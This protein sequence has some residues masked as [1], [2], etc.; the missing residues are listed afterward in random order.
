MIDNLIARLAYETARHFIRAGAA[1]DEGDQPALRVKNLLDAEAEE[2]LRI[3][4][5]SA[6]ADGLGDVRVVVAQDSNLECDDCFR[7]D[8]EKS[9]TWYRNNN[10]TGLLYL[11]T[12]VES[13]EQG[14]ES[15]FTVQDRNYLDGSLQTVGF[16]PERRIV[17]LA[18][19]AVNGSDAP[20]P[21][22]LAERVSEVRLRLDEN[23]VGSGVRAFAA[24]ALGVSAEIRTLT[25][26]AVDH[27]TLDRGVGLA[28]PLLNLLPDEDWASDRDVSRRLLLN[29]RLADHMNPSGVDQDPEV[30][31]ALIRAAVFNDPAGTPLPED[32]NRAWRA[33]CERYVDQ[34]LEEHRRS[35]PFWVYR[36]VF[37]KAAVMG[38]PL[39]D[40][41]REEL[42]AT[43]PDRV[44][45]FD[46]LNVRDGLNLRDAESARRLVE[47]APSPDAPEAG[48]LV[49]RLL[50]A[51][52]KLLRRLAYPRAR[53][54]RDPF[55]RIIEMV[56]NAGAPEELEGAELEVMCGRLV[57]ADGPSVDLFAF[58]YGSTL[59]E[60][61]AM[62][63]TG[64]TGLVLRIEE[65]L[66]TPGRPPPLRTVLGE[67]ELSD[68]HPGVSGPDAP[69][70]WPGVPIELRLWK[71]DGP[72][73]VLI[74]EATNLRWRP[75]DIEWL[76][77]GWLMIAAEDA[78]ANEPFLSSSTS[79]FAQIVAHAIERTTPLA[80]LIVARP[81]Q[82][83]VSCDPTL[84]ALRTAR[85]SFIAE[86]ASGGLASSGIEAYAETW[87][88]L[89]HEVRQSFVPNGVLDERL[90]A[91]AA[92]DVVHCEPQSRALMLMSH[93]LRLRWLARHL[94]E[95][96]RVCSE[97]L[98][99]S[100]RLNSV[101]EGHYLENLELLSAHGQPPLLANSARTLL[102]PVS[103]HGLAEVYA[104]IKQEGQ[105]T[106]AWRA[107]VDEVALR[108]VARQLTEYLRAHPHKSDGV[109]LLLVL[110]AGGS[111]PG[112]LVR[113]VRRGEF[114]DVP[115]RCHVLA[116]RSS[117]ERIVAG[118]QDLETGNR[119][120][121]SARLNPPLQLEL[122]DWQGEVH[123]AGQ[124]EGKQFDL[125]IVPNFF[126]DKVDVNEY[127]DAPRTAAGRFDPLYDRSTYVDLE[128]AAGAVSIVLRPEVSDPVLEDWS[129]I[130]VRLLRSEAIAPLSPDWTDYVKLRIR[131]EE[132]AQL[133][134]ALHECSH[135]VI[136]L[137]RYVGRNQI[138]NLPQ[139]PD[140]LTVREGVGQSGLSTLVVSSNTGRDFV[141]QRLRRKLE[142][143]S[144]TV[145]GLDVE[146]LA[147]GVYDEIREVAPGLILRSMGISRVTEEVL[148]L[149]VAKRIAEWEV[150]IPADATS[151]WISLDEHSEWFGG[152]SGI[153]ADLCRI[154]L[155]R[156][157]GRLQVGVLVVE[158]KLRQAYD[159]HGEAQ[160]SRS[161]R[162]IGEA[163]DPDSEDRADAP[164]WRRAVLN[165]L[166]AVSD[167][168]SL[169][170]VR[171]GVAIPA[172]LHDEDRAA[173][174]AGDYQLAVLRAVYSICLYDR[175]GRLERSDAGEVAVFR[176]GAEQVLDLIE[177]RMESARPSSAGSALKSPPDQ[178]E[179]G[180]PPALTPA[181]FPPL[182]DRPIGAPV[183]VLVPG[184]IAAP[185]VVEISPERRGMDPQRMQRFYQVILDT[186]EEFKVDVRQPR[187]G[188]PNFIEGP[189]FVKYRLLPG[190]GVD[191]RRL[192]ERE[193]ALRLALGL[194]E[195]KRLRFVIGG[196]TVNIDVPKVDEDR[197]FVRAEDM[198]ARWDETRSSGRLAVP[199]GENQLGEVVELDFSSANSPHLLIG[200]MTG[201][202]KSEALNTILRGL[203]RLYGPDQL[204][205]VLVDPKQTELAP[206]EDS[207]HLLG[208]IG[209]FAEDAVICLEAAVAEMEDRYSR[210]RAAGQGVRDLPTY[211]AKVT[212]SER[213]PWHLIVLDEYADL[214]T[215]PDVRRKV[216]GAV[217][218]ISQKARACGIHL[219]IATQKPSSE[220]ISTTIRSNLPAQLALRCRGVVESRVVMDEAGAETLNG[221]GDAFLKLAS[222]IERIQCARAG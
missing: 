58:L 49:D 176:A 134:S 63:A 70:E 191:P 34:P 212:E 56:R 180:Q 106:T 101:N 45:E 118:F 75:E 116:P 150:P 104:A 105:T 123:A 120:A 47:A 185:A 71:G 51:T 122:I 136:T 133:F 171:E 95:L 210:F 110:P 121:G 177:G 174:L 48:P 216:E 107:E 83:S 66:L 7:A 173:L 4:L 12:K 76:A 38:V 78:P 8:P 209:Y 64:S 152:D 166:R 91:A 143:L 87:E 22:R 139:R 74:D 178:F 36:Q 19:A 126:G 28:L 53:E 1:A 57:E 65:R 114:R 220:N 170:R 33:V 17:E 79:D 200:G 72:G 192:G 156:R 131:F 222:G 154:D 102:V 158:G 55:T 164:F 23:G 62:A 198:W 213:L 137:D 99:L 44:G 155:V 31:K 68:D 67:D 141:V 10:P 128:A 15:M 59:T 21:R 29:H 129:T 140:V 135:W 119:M 81:L 82:A 197:Y 108:D 169:R 5:I 20:P 179:P 124:L 60:I 206:F 218:R 109:S 25:T 39:G 175:P 161:L 32:D 149:M 186:F 153:R 112:E 196:G 199:L 147:I 26:G 54:F 219:I 217:K 144:R 113:R 6:G 162:L 93:P 117:W 145:V 86:A 142:R 163:L 181:S 80:E 24:F 195:G 115:I 182:D 52:Q 85:A 194:E 37:A 214:I 42:A 172:E 130:N 127:A 202:G 40:R 221:K 41:A 148:G 132:A 61:G 30:L 94:R 96:A 207:P 190:R 11:Q 167:K 205:L 9:I 88:L 18:W 160:A 146:A 46:E 157:E 151:V 84:L 125:A 73:R 14:L 100:L 13:D 159:A 168:A 201:S 189:A 215:E 183:A 111:V 193:E 35:T 3:W 69:V 165:A 2:L 27:A 184:D 98:A 188:G 77:F 103:E 90:H 203:T 208:S 187:D 89:L 43:A 92:Q 204:R 16:A 138:E 97:A 211:N 50:A